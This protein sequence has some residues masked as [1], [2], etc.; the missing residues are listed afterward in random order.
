MTLRAF[1]I[2]VYPLY[3]IMCTHIYGM[4]ENLPSRIALYEE[5][6]LC[7]WIAL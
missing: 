5:D 2:I 1:G 4:G 7:G 6:V 3:I